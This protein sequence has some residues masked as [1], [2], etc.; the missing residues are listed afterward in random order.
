M[1]NKESIKT[2][3]KKLLSW[4]AVLPVLVLISCATIKI[5]MIIFSIFTPVG[6]LT[7]FLVS[8][9]LWG[10]IMLVLSISYLLDGLK[11]LELDKNTEK[12]TI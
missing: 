5:L 8:L 6:F 3:L 4:S 10:N 7:I 2:I 9:S 1:E 12:A 11:E